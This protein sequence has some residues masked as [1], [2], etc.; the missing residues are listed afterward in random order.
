MARDLP[1]P[2]P[3][4]VSVWRHD[5]YA[6]AARTVGFIKRNDN[7]SEIRFNWVG[8][9]SLESLDWISLGKSASPS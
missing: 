3:A 2:D 7:I 6:D 9:G 1:K 8:S 5:I 4:N